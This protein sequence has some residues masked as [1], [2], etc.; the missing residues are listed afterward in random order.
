[1]K[2]ARWIRSG[3]SRTYSLSAADTSD[4]IACCRYARAGARVGVAHSSRRKCQ[5]LRDRGSP[6]RQGN[7][8]RFARL[9]GTL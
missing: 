1:M 6:S 7:W 4:G 2:G 8:P 3:L 5:A 9:A